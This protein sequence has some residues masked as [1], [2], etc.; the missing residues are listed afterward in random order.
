MKRTPQRR[1]F[2]IEIDLSRYG[3]KTAKAVRLTQCPPSSKGFKL[4]LVVN[5]FTVSEELS[6]Y[7]PVKKFKI[8][9]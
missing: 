1:I 2:P 8:F 4:Q 7:P 5:R 3:F 9:I 6:L